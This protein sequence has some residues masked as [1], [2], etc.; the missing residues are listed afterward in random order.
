MPLTPASSDQRPCLTAGLQLTGSLPGSRD[1]L[2]VIVKR[3]AVI[4]TRYLKYKQLPLL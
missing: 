2:A 4:K 3:Q 1:T